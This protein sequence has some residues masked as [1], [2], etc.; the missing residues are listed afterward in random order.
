MS[1]DLVPPE[2]KHASIGMVILF[3]VQK[4]IEFFKGSAE[5][6]DAKDWRDKTTGLLVEIKTTL[7]LADAAN[8][9]NEADVRALQITSTDHEHRLTILEARR[10]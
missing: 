3:A 5:V 1:D 6:K 7:A 2:M 9:R 8:R 10:P 4:V